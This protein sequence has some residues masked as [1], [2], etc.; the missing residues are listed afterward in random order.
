MGLVGRL[1]LIHL[2]KANLIR[3]IFDRNS[4]QLQ[5]AWLPLDGRCNLFF[6]SC[7]IVAQ[8]R[9]IDFQLS[10]PNK[11]LLGRE[12]VPIYCGDY[13]GYTRAKS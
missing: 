1:V 10:E 6:Q 4:I 2:E 3:M 11:R 13:C 8:L 12:S 9:R 7:F 5:H